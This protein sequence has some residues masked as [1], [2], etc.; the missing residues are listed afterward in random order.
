MLDHFSMQFAARKT[1]AWAPLT[2]PGQPQSGAFVSR[3]A[4]HTIAADWFLLSG[5]FGPLEL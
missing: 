1:V 2:P 3:V 5:A 4:R